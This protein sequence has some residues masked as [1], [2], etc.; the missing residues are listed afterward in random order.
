VFLPPL[1]GE[2]G[3]GEETLGRSA[4][5]RRTPTPP[6][7]VEGE[8]P[9]PRLTT[10][11][12]PNSIDPPPSRGRGVF[13]GDVPEILPPVSPPGGKGTQGRH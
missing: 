8:G 2:G 11:F 7:R 5:L 3:D 4:P 9:T 12:V 13:E 10:K 1:V 6:S